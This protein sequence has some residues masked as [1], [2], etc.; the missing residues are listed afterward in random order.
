MKFFEIDTKK[1]FS[2]LSFGEQ[3]KVQ[4]AFAL[5]QHPEILILDEPT[6]GIDPTGRSNILDMLMDFMQ[7][8]NHSILLSTHI[9]SDL[10]KI[11][12]YVTLIDKGEIVFSQDKNSMQEN[13][14]LVRASKDT[15]TEA[16]KKELI[17]V[18][19]N[20]FG[21]EA[22]TTSKTLAEKP[23]VTAVIP[24]IEDIMIHLVGNSDR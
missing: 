2:N 1:I 7:D 17:G 18:K 21:I 4:I 12:D 10:D 19:E 22:I 5:A 9:T 23:G 24:T 16:E 6:T 14:R 8:E 13:F 20:S 3:K 11:A 15:F